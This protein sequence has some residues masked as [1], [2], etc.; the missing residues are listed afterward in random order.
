MLHIIQSIIRFFLVINTTINSKKLKYI[1]VSFLQFLILIEVS[2]EFF[3]YLKDARLA[4]NFFR[5][6]YQP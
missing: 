2:I 4:G 6:S 5:S 3:T 1:V